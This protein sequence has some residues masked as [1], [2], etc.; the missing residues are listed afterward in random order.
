[1][2]PQPSPDTTPAPTCDSGGH[3]NADVGPDSSGDPDAN[4]DAD[5]DAESAAD[6]DSDAGGSSR[7]RRQTAVPTPTPVADAD[8]DANG[9]PS[10]TDA[11][12]VPTPTPAAVPTPTPAATPTVM[13]AVPSNLRWDEYYNR[14]IGALNNGNANLAL[15]YLQQAVK[16]RPGSAR[17][18]RVSG[19]ASVEYFPYY[20]MALAL[21]QMGDLIAARQA[22]D[23]EEKQKVIQRSALGRDFETLRSRLAQVPKPSGS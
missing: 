19:E 21:L 22:F 1:M 5:T 10:H 15:A 18:L 23:Q 20:Y 6:P 14:G 3:S 13:P 12:G 17:A 2:V 4:N 9:T 7:P 8:P 16:S 11:S